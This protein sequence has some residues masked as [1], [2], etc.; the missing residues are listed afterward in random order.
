MN[1]PIKVLIREKPVGGYSAIVPCFPGC[2]TEGD[3]IEELKANLLEAIEGW[4]EVTQD[5]ALREAELEEEN[6]SGKVL[7]L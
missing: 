7:I 4:F 5:D 6:A 2:V 1:L 3:T